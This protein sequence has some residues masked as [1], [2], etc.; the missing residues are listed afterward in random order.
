MKNKV[1][2]IITIIFG[3]LAALGPKTIFPVCKA[4]EMKMRCFYTARWELVVGV[5]AVIT[6]IL[7][8]IISK[9]IIRAVLSGVQIILGVFIVLIPTAIVGV[10]GSP[11]MHCVTV[12]RPAL[13]VIGTL[14]IVVSSTALIV[15]LRESIGKRI[16]LKVA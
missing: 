11:M 16:G 6:G 15:S 7:L 3:L 8:L 10:C 4:G 5:A 12:T 9:E 1:L 14:H 13:I 2:A